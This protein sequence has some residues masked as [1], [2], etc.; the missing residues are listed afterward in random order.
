MRKPNKADIIIGF[1]PCLSDQGPA[2]SAKIHGGMAVGLLQHNE[3]YSNISD[4]NCN[5]MYQMPSNK[6]I[7]YN[8]LNVWIGSIVSLRPRKSFRYMTSYD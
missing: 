6:I 1:L 2:K 8:I 5:I 3:K 4:S 7:P